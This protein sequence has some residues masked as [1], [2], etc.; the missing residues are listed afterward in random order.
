MKR[1]LVG[2]AVRDYLLQIPIKERDWVIIGATKEDMLN[3]GYYQVGKS[4][5]VFLHPES[6]EEYALA[7][8]EKKTGIGYTGFSCYS[9]PRVS[10][11]EDLGRRD[12]TI[13]AIAIDEHGNFFDPYHGREDVKKRLL[14]HI[15]TSF[16]EDPLRVLRVAR[17]A[18]RLCHLNFRIAPETLKIMRNM[19]NELLTLSPERVWKETEK[20]LETNNPQ[21]YFQVLYD[22]NAL[23]VL[24][25]EISSLFGVPMLVK[26]NTK[27]DTGIHTLMA[28]SIAS[29]LSNDIVVRFSTLCHDFGKGLTP[30]EQWPNHYNH[31]KI[32]I[33]IIEKL[34]QRLKIPNSLRELTKIIVKYQN[35]IKNIETLTPN[36]LIKLFYDIDVWRHPKRLEQIILVNESNIKG[37]F[38]FKKNTYLQRDFL[39]EAYHVASSVNVKEI[40]KFGYSSIR[41]GIELYQRRKD[42][43]ENWEKH[44]IK[45]RNKKIY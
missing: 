39:R 19:I 42:A 7:R 37:Y 9:S 20:A 11:E 29:Q 4:F 28:V 15:S 8:I 24:F 23:Q 32:G 45:N 38:D 12:L 33:K 31:E 34:C 10:L 5:P 27:I 40:I 3:A 36:I 16:S 35:I 6:H 43:L 22:S 13:N 14:R 41:I 17:F 1:Y 18:A 2:G 25:P 44:H 30:K 21:I 26:W